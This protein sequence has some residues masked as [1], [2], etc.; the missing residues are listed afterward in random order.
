MSDISVNSSYLQGSLYTASGSD[1]SNTSSDSS[2][3]VS[4]PSTTGDLLRLN[5]MASGLD[6]DKIVS[7][8]MAP[9][10]N[11]IDRVK[12]SIQLVQWKQQA[13]LKIINDIKDFQNT[14]LNSAQPDMNIT[15]SSF[16]NIMAAS[17]TSSDV[18]VSTNS[19]AREGNYKLIINNLAESAA[20]TS[21]PLGSQAGFSDLTGAGWYGHNITFKVGD[22]EETITLDASGDANDVSGVV[23]D[24]NKKIAGNQNLS[25]KVTA[26][27]VT[28]GSSTYIKFTNTSGSDVKITG[29]DITDLNAIMNKNIVSISSNTKLSD[30]GLTDSGTL[31]FKYNSTEFRVDITSAS[32]TLGQLADDISKESSGQVALSIDDITGKLIFK[33]SN[34]G[35][36]NNLSITNGS[37]ASLLDALG[38]PSTGLTAQGID[39]KLSVNGTTIQE[40]SNSFTLNGININL[41]NANNKE[42]NVSVSSNTDSVFTKFKGFMDKYNSIVSEIRDK[43]NEKITFDYPPLTDAQKKQMSDSDITAWNN[44]AQQGILHSDDNLENLLN[45]LKNTFYDTIGSG[46]L[47]FGSKM[48]LDLSGDYTKDGTLVFTDGTGDTFKQTLKDHLDEITKLFTKAADA[49]KLGNDKY[50]NEGIFQKINDIVVDNTGM[51][52]VTSTSSILGKMALKQDDYSVYGSGGTN[53][54]LDQIYQYNLR[55]K[56]LQNTFSTKQTQYY[57]EFTSLETALNSLNAQSAMIF[58]LT[59]GS[60]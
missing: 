29:S 32:E 4:A 33:T 21:T 42:I 30:L 14:Y 22:T 55:I 43:V 25:G 48:G 39:A 40:S 52:G 11:Q 20:I 10:Q 49:G 2:S 9:Y 1:S 51:T 5:G 38:L 3:S 18:T 35:S 16:F 12:Q 45:A 17:S 6:V 36:N 27:Y 50:N 15:S 24:I 8:M 34:T 7:Q 23:K 41:V 26:S 46:G 47:S 13:Y 31:N 37:T 60:Y 58:Q 57:N 59:G 54:F 56:T 53:T 44:K 28:E 19:D